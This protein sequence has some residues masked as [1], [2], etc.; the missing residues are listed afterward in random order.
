M[1]NNFETVKKNLAIILA[2]KN[3]KRLKNKHLILVKG[4]PIIQYTFDYAKKSPVLN[5]IVCST[6]CQNI[7]SL[8]A[9]N[10]IEVIKR[11]D[12][13]ASDESHIIEAVRYTL[14]QYLEREG[15]LPETTVILYGNAPYRK[16]NIKVA[17]EFLYEMDAD[18]VFPACNVLRFHPQWM[19]KRGQD[20][21]M[22]LK[23][24]GLSYRCQDLPEYF[25]D[26]GAFIV[27]KSAVLLNRRPMINLYSDFGDKIYF[28]E[29]DIDAT[30]DIDE[31][32]DLYHFEYLISKNTGENQ[33]KYWKG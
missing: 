22:I 33:L 18:A 3:S 14:R 17:V 13:L 8:A 24:T 25:L 30:V 32:N 6:D 20:N 11:P 1:K 15:F 31:V 5:H 19:F 16:T 2:R 7:S 23:E 21:K 26:T 10:G 28:I 29:E 9:M 27:A 12:E 4:K